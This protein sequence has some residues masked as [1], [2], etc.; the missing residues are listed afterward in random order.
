MAWVYLVAA[1][2]LEIVFALGLKFS[3]GFTRWRPTVVFLVG[4]AGSF[5]LLTRA[6]QTLPVGT[7]Y[8]VWTGIGAAGT[9]IVGMLFLEEPR[10]VARLLS[11][12]LIVAGVVGLRLSEGW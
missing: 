3:E 2:L 8:A 6:L 9:A 10:T 11:I 12:V 7:A 4:G 1:G 5:Y